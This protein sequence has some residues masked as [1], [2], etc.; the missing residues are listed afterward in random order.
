MPRLT[1]RHTSAPGGG[2]ALRTRRSTGVCSSPCSR[3]WSASARRPRSPRPTASRSPA[4]F[5][6]N[7]ILFLAVVRVIWRKPIWVVVLGA[8]VFGTVEVTFFASTL[9]KIVHG[10]WLPIAAALIVFTSADDLAAG[11]GDPHPQPHRRRKDRCGSSSR[12]C[13]AANPPIYRVPGTAVFLNA[14]PE[15]TPLALRANVEHNHALHENVRHRVDHV[16]EGAARPGI[17][18]ARHRRP[19]LPRRRHQPHHGPLRLPGRAGHPGSAAL[20]RDRRARDPGGHRGRD[21][22]PVADDDR[23]DTGPGDARAGRNGCSWRSRRTPRTQRSTSGC[24][25]T[26]PSAWAPRSASETRAY[27]WNR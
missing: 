18:A 9:T 22:L 27:G 1:I 3:S 10:G 2:P 14:N 5:I 20:P 4:T 15:T 11:P 8:V 12:S 23:A 7:T 17:G 21:L 13:T 26:A 24:R 16:R 6:L 25:P 19:R